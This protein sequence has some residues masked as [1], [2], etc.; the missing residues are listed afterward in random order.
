MATEGTYVEDV[1]FKQFALAYLRPRYLSLAIHTFVA[2]YASFKLIFLTVNATDVLERWVFEL[3]PLMLMAMPELYLLSAS[4]I[5]AATNAGLHFANMGTGRLIRI[6]LTVTMVVSLILGLRTSPYYFDAVNAGRLIVLGALLLTVPLD[7]IGAIRS[8]LHL[9]RARGADAEFWAA[10]PQQF[11]EVMTSVDEALG[12]LDT[13][14]T[15]EEA[16]EELSEL[17][18]DLLEDL[19]TTISDTSG[20]P[21][22]VE[23]RRPDDLEVERRR[24]LFEKRLGGHRQEAG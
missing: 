22:E 21:A 3:T 7:H 17:A 20:Q 15:K 5:V 6:A 4:V 24:I 9:G 2:F 13:S 18:T 8:R 12:L 10:E 14:Q 1:Q 19:M 11:D 16:D 23:G